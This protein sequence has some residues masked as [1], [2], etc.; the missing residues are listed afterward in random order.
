MAHARWLL[1]FLTVFAL[2]CGLRGQVT[3]KPN[4]PWAPIAAALERLRSAATQA[5][6]LTEAD[7]AKLKETLDGAERQI[8]EGRAAVVASTR[9]AETTKTAPDR[10]ESL[11][12]RL[13][14]PLPEPRIPPEG[15]SRAELQTALDQ[16]TSQK[17]IQQRKLDDARQELARTGDR[18]TTLT[19]SIPE[20]QRTLQT[21]PTVESG[22]GGSL[23]AQADRLLARS[24]RLTLEASLRAA[25]AEIEASP[26]YEEVTLLERDN[27]E[28][29]VAQLDVVQRGLQK[30]LDEARAREAAD[31]E[32][33]AQEAAREAM[34][35]R[36]ELA[37]LAAQTA[38]LGRKRTKAEA[39]LAAARQARVE[40]E[41]HL[42][43]VERVSA[44]LTQ[45]LRNAGHD[46]AV[47]AFLRQQKARLPKLRSVATRLSAWRESRAIIER[48]DVED[49]LRSLP[50]PVEALDAIAPNASEAERR[51]LADGVGPL[52]TQ[53]RE[54]LVSLR[55]T[56][57]DLERELL[58]IVVGRAELINHT[59]ELALA[60]NERVLWVRSAEPAWS[61]DLG[62]VR[63][64]A[65][66]LADPSQWRALMAAVAADL[67][68]NVGLALLV[69]VLI[70]LVVRQRGLRQRLEE[71]A[72]VA[73]RRSCVAF[74]P[75]AQALLFTA[76]VALPLPGLLLLVAWRLELGGDESELG[77]A[78]GAGL[79]RV[80]FILLFAEILRRVARD[81]G[82]G[83]AHFGW[84]ERTR[85]AFR[86]LLPRVLVVALPSGMLFW[87]LDAHG[88]S[89]WRDGLGRPALVLFLLAVGVG[90]HSLLHP[91]TG[92]LAPVE[93][94]DA[95]H[96]TTRLRRLWYLLGV[97]VPL[98]L[99]VLAALGWGF[100]AAQLTERLI[101]TLGALL[102][103]VLANE[104]TVRWL[105]VSRRRLAM[106]QA[107]ARRA[108]R[109]E[110]AND[111]AALAA[112]EQEAIDLARVD[113]QSRK[114][115]HAAVALVTL[116]SAYWI[117]VDVLPA[118]GILHQAKL[119][120][121]GDE[122]ITLGNLL[123]ALIIVVMAVVAARNL[124]GAL[125]MALLRHSS[126]KQGER[127]AVATLGRYAILLVGLGMG[128]SAIGIGWSKVQWL[129]AA[130]SVGLG[131]GLQEVFANFVS[132]IILLFERPLRVGDMV[133]VGDTIG[134]VSRIR[135]RATT[136]LD[137][138]RREVIIPNRE[139]I[140]GRLVNWTLTDS[141][142]RLKIPV[143]VAYGT[144]TARARALL[145]QAAREC[146]TVMHDP[147]PVATF[148]GFGDSTLNLE[149]W[150]HVEDTS[151]RVAT[152]TALHERIAS[153]FREA[154][155]EI[156]FPQRDVHLYL[157]PGVEPDA[158]SNA[159]QGSAAS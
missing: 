22:E 87:T 56:Y 107:R 28:R 84:Q 104:V 129:A 26:L 119:W 145:L 29:E 97:G 72:T 6:D 112:L 46:Q 96:W 98:S 4:D 135:I 38:E 80:G 122:A 155:I 75:T 110:A 108:A 31:A 27:L 131:F 52:L 40:L 25:Q 5:S 68:A 58:R 146:P 44:D 62:A 37:D 124:P 102:L 126:V 19:S 12:K 152:N 67:A 74:K 41:A 150:V 130:I 95:A 117:W 142:T 147:M 128:F 111:P 82:L 90:L 48:L 11:R 49:R 106:E 105:L 35:G 78:L 103:L 79:R 23:Q 54:L 13:A 51:S 53:Q 45:R 109:Q 125:T 144:D 156:A 43:E 149:L 154:R 36:P 139:F 77:H 73:R 136:I 148:L 8:Q 71:I 89:T 153:L 17:E 14:T 10:R 118:L 99:L 88:V 30:R 9:W 127:Y 85:R 116:V 86:R 158:L 134:T 70:V 59:D 55:S 151:N 100:T 33:K 63:D 138:D 137:F 39:D 141:I 42:Q 18:R 61:L 132:G 60:I 101:F 115:V 20:V 94:T 133:S 91:D 3:A 159:V 81:G 7:A 16:L 93:G 57:G 15:A 24:K 47:G 2:G 69:L 140:T 113:E 76:L 123:K 114:L 32:R 21:L 66:W 83:E 64:A 143:G 92:V 120:Q 65:R 1:L 121:D 34:Q 157:Q 50:T